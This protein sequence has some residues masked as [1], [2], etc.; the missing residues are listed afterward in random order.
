MSGPGPSDDALIRARRAEPEGTRMFNIHCASCHGE[1]GN[2]PGVVRVLG[3]SA[4]SRFD[5]ARELF[6]YTSVEMPPEGKAANLSKEEHWA[7]ARYMMQ[8]SRPT[9]R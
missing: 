5:D 9:S 2:A 3:P 6:E 8:A 1:L 4:L 7:V